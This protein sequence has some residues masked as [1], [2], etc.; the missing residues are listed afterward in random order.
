[1]FNKQLADFPIFPVATLEN[2]LGLI[3]KHSVPAVPDR[4]T[5]GRTDG[6][7]VDSLNARPYG[8]FCLPADDAVAACLKVT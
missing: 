7:W 2:G 6:T 1:M 5:L 3:D 4:P 8:H